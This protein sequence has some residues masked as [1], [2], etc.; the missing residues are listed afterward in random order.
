VLSR[1]IEARQSLNSGR[2]L[3]PS[4]RS[5]ILVT[6]RRYFGTR[7]PGSSP[8]SD[9]G[10]YGAKGR[11]GGAARFAAPTTA[12]GWR[13]ARIRAALKPHDRNTLV[14]G[15]ASL[16]ADVLLLGRCRRLRGDA[17]ALDAL[18]SR[19]NVGIALDGDA[20]QMILVDEKGA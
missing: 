2:G 19:G 18:R 10:G 15:F 14:A 12:I 6:A 11:L 7:R 5:P 9:H 4:S 1:G 16:G 3:A 17:D 20:D 8:Q 13:S